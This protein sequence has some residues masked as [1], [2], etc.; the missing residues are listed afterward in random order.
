MALF[1]LIAWYGA[2]LTWDEYSFEVS[3]SGLGVPQWLYTVWMPVLCVAVCARI[4]GR[5][6]RVLR[7]AADVSGRQGGGR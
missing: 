1:A 6:A 5:I 4:G 3:S 7:A 2:K